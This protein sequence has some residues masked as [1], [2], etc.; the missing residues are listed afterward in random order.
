MVIA[1]KPIAPHAE[2]RDRLYAHSGKMVREGDRL[3]ASEKAWGAV[4]H[5]LKIVAERRNWPYAGHADAKVI[6]KRIAD[7]T[8]NYKAVKQFDDVEELHR[9]YYADVYPMEDI[10]TRRASAKVS[11]PSSRKP[12]PNCPATRRG[13]PNAATGIATPAGK[14]KRRCTR[15]RRGSAGIR[16]PSRRR[17]EEY[18]YGH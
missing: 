8:G 14:R 4:A 7:L 9:N 16:R 6:I 17:R 12:T 1:E 13:Q 15:R 5:A 11:S 10:K 3:Q 18:A 2:H